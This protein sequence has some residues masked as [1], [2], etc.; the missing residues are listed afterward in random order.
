MQ[1]YSS[2]TESRWTPP[3]TCT[4]PILA[5]IASARSIQMESLPRCL[6]T[7]KARLGS[8]STPK[9]T[10][11]SPTFGNGYDLATSRIIKLPP[12]GT[13]TAVASAI[14]AGGIAVDGAGNLYATDGRNH[15][16]RKISP[17]GNTMTIAGN[18]TSAYWGDGGPAISSGLSGPGSLA[19]DGLGRLYIADAP[20]NRIRVIS[21]DGVITTA[22]GNGTSGYS[23]EGG[24]AVGAGLTYPTGVTTDN[25]GGL[26]IADSGDERVLKVPLNGTITTAAGNGTRG[27]SGDGGPGTAAELNLGVGVAADTSGNIFIADIGNGRIRKLASSGIITTVAGNGISGYSGD[28]G[29]ATAAQLNSSGRIAVD[30]AGNLYISGSIPD[31]H[32]RKVTPSGTISTV[33]ASGAQGSLSNA[34]LAVDLAGNIYAGYLACLNC[35]NI[36][37]ASVLKIEP[38]GTITR[39]AGNG[40]VGYSGDGGLATSAQLSGVAGLAVDSTGNVYFS[41]GNA[42]RVLRPIAG[43]YPTVDAITNAASNLLAPLAP[44]EIFVLYGSGMGPSQLGQ[45]HLNNNGLVDTTLAETQVTFNGIPAPIVY[46]SD[47]QLAAIV[48]YSVQGPSADLVVSYQG[49]A[50]NPMPVLINSAS[51][52]L[53]TLDSSGQGQA[54]AVNQ[55]GT[56]NSAANPAPAGSIVSLY[57]TGEGAT[58]P[59]GVDGKLASAPLPKPVLPVS[60]A[61]AGQP[62]TV[63]YAGGAPGLVAGVMQVNVQIPVGTP[64]GNAAVILAVGTASSQST[65]TIAVQ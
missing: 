52:A 14:S 47:K 57:V 7:S 60:V 28:G 65:V 63:Q 64:S 29:P 34:A 10:C 35:T 27:Y 6:Q 61:I 58:S 54:A 51:P 53:F 8:R 44:G 38:S 12:G 40:T 20:D 30:G 37:A 55:D 62:A 18:G 1:S 42:V 21:S 45:M 31:Q 33:G 13:I 19:L 17:N 2:P 50:T 46:T 39:I 56:I 48:P 16:V 4:S 23:G 25:Y 24:P 32:I 11:T 41:D 43:P 3:A 15:L 5:I 26:Y 59:A 9:A 22:A 36:S 49:H